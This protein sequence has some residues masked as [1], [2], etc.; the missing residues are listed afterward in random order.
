MTPEQKETA[1]AR[2]GQWR[3]AVEQELQELITHATQ[4]RQLSNEAKTKTKRTY[5]NKKFKKVSSDVMQMVA[6]MQRIDAHRAELESRGD[7]HAPV[8]R[9]ELA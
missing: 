1:G 3:V 9:N 8:S 2:I 7:P 4:I 6:A 5:Y